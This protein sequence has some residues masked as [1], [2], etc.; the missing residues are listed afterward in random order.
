MHVTVMPLSRAPGKHSAEVIVTVFMFI[1]LYIGYVQ[2]YIFSIFFFFPGVSAY[3]DYIRKAKGG[4]SY[5]TSRIFSI[6]YIGL[7][8]Q[9]NPLQ[10]ILWLSWF[11]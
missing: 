3:C 2:P 5:Y 11:N 7:E 8:D 4:E 6:V 1:G 10:C 9:V